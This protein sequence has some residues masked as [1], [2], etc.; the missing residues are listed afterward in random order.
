V[1]DNNTVTQ[2]KKQTTQVNPYPTINNLPAQH[3]TAP[4]HSDKLGK[5]D[6]QGER[7]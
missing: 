6:N 2:K 1:L 3:S 4:Q 7:R 5:N